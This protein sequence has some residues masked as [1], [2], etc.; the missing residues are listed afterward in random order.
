MG[1]DVVLVV[2]GPTISHPSLLNILF[3]LINAKYTT[4]AR[5]F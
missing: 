5:V 1:A 4:G 3:M 2:V